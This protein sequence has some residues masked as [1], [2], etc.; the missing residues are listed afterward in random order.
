MRW[1]RFDGHGATAT[2][3]KQNMPADCASEAQRINRLDAP[4]KFTK[5][6]QYEFS[7]LPGDRCIVSTGRETR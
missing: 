7:V 5:T 6:V 1:P 2:A 3:G 4:S